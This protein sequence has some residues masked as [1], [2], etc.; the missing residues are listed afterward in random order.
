MQDILTS[1]VVLVLVVVL[2]ALMFM[3][4]AKVVSYS[5]EQEQKAASEAM[6]T[7]DEL[8]KRDPV[9]LGDFIEKFG[10]PDQVT[11]VTC[12][13][14]RCIKARWDLT[15]VFARCWQRLEVVLKEEDKKLFFYELVPLEEIKI[16]R[17]NTEVEVCAEG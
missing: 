14:S 10:E 13:G 3:L 4:T 6:A 15:T 17:G 1:V 11:N 16:K 5:L 9:A 2:G 8:V 7:I 12:E